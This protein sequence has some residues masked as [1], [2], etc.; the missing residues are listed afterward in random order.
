MGWSA[1][2]IEALSQPNW[3]PVWTVRRRGVA[4]EPGSAWEATSHPQGPAPCRIGVVSLEGASVSAR[5]WTSSIGA[6]SVELVGDPSEAL[7]AL[8]RGSFVELELKLGVWVERVATGQVQ[9][10]RGSVP[11]F[12]LECWDLLSALRSP[13]TT[14]PTAEMFSSVAAGTTTSFMH[15]VGVATYTV[16]STTGFERE[17]GGKGAFLVNNGSTTYYRL[18]N[19]S[20]ATTFTIDTPA[21]ATVGNT[22]DAGCGVVPI[23]EIAYIEGHPV[24]IAGK[25][26][27]STGT[28]TNGPDDL[29]PDTWGLELSQDLW[30]RSD[31]QGVKAWVVVNSG[32]YTW[33]LFRDEAET[34]PLGWLEG[35]LSPAG[36]WLTQRQGALTL[37]AMCDSH[38]GWVAVAPTPVLTV[39]DADVIDIVDYEAFD[40]S[41][42][43]EF[44]QVQ[45]TDGNGATSAGSADGGDTFTLPTQNILVQVVDSIYDNVGELR[46]DV[47]RRLAEAACRIPE[48]LVLRLLTWKT[49]QLCPGDQIVLDLLGKRFVSRSAGVGS[50]YGTGGFRARVAV[51]YEVVPQVAD[52]TVRVGCWVYPD[53]EYL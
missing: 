7:L 48:R 12:T 26:L 39:T 25:L 28:G 6:F 4:D 10:I 21:D 44:N 52:F 53:G 2:F 37:R 27:T 36:L 49:A 15:I 13:L 16:V 43:T 41:H 30:D 47:T 22:T 19:A 1:G 35:V 34:D 31:A 51:V 40:S 17:T 8:P 24:D 14:D 20:T 18:W 29:L 46:A 45:C 5:S 3:A 38:F 33:Q 50:I 32:D 11:S 42:N 23:A 9:T